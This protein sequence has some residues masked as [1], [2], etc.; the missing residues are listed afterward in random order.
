[1]KSKKSNPYPKQSQVALAS[2]N[3]FKHLS[4]QADS[5]QESSDEE[6]K[7]SVSVKE[8]CTITDDDLKTSTAGKNKK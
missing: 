7:I 8:V 4:L 1:M 2:L 3:S 5:S 6:E